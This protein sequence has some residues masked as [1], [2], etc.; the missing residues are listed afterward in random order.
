LNKNLETEA[1]LEEEWR[2]NNFNLGW[3]RIRKI[4]SQQSNYPQ[5]SGLGSGS[6]IFLIYKLNN[7]MFIGP[8]IVK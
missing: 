7:N 6:E 1:K 8:F 2:K 5:I 3:I 4:S